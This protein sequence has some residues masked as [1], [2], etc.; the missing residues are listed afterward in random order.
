MRLDYGLK[1][2][3][4]SLESIVNTIGREGLKEK[5][6]FISRLVYLFESRGAPILELEMTIFVVIHC[7]C[8]VDETVLAPMQHPDLPS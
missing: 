5:R 2:I 3:D 8:E 1:S 4:T 6:E 7:N